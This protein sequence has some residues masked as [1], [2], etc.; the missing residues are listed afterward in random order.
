MTRT[1]FIYGALVGSIFLS[2][3]P[4]LRA[5]TFFKDHASGWHWYDETVNKETESKEDTSP[6]SPATPPKPKTPEEHIEAYKAELQRR[7]AKAWMH[8]TPSNVMAYQDMQKDMVDRSKT[9]STVWMTNVYNTP[10]LDHTLISPVNQKARHIHLDLE[11]QRTKDVIKRLSQSYG[12]FF[13]FSSGCEYCHRFAPIV[14]A[15]SKEHA[16]EVL[17]IST[18]GGTL[19]DFPRMVPD[20]GLVE[21][22]NIQVLPSLYAVNPTTGHVIPIAHGMISMDQMEA[23][24]MALEGRK[25]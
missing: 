17:A 1:F 20:N 22:W 25:E 21:Q 19:E 24:I 10:S 6:S 5:E 8:P 9:F 3:H 23:R 13:F 11:K 14:M 7:F 18:D 4:S 16:W 12:L 15:F 2:T